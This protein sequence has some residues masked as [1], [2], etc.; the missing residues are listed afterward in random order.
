MSNLQFFIERH[1]TSLGSITCDFLRRC[2]HVG[3]PFAIEQSLK[4]SHKG[5]CNN[6][7]NCH[8]QASDIDVS[9]I[10]GWLDFNHAPADIQRSQQSVLLKRSSTFAL[11]IEVSGSNPTNRIYYQHKARLNN[12]MPGILGAMPSIVGFK[13]RPIEK[14]DYITRYNQFE[15]SMLSEVRSKAQSIFS[16]PE[17]MVITDDVLALMDSFGL[18]TFSLF[19]AAEVDSHRSS[20]AVSF[21]C[22][23]SEMEGFIAGINSVAQNN[24]IAAEIQD[25]DLRLTANTRVNSIQWGMAGDEKPFLT[26]YY[27]SFLSD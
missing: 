13:W 26:V 4:L 8:F 1:Q 6:R 25:T 17:L 22:E 27:T 7:V 10:N 20:L 15:V 2:S 3:Q 11:G 21:K 24:G 18:D 9:R 23:A 16:T 12:R 14:Q 5:V 19:V